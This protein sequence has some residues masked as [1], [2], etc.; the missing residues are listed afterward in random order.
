M[1]FM[2][3]EVQSLVH[4]Q[5]WHV[6]P[7]VVN[8]TASQ[9]DEALVHDHSVQCED[10][11]DELAAQRSLFKTMADGD[12]RPVHDAGP[13]LAKMWHRIDHN[14]LRPELNEPVPPP[15][16]SGM[17][18]LRWTRFL[19]A[20][21]VVQAVGL[22]ALI[23]MVW[24]PRPAPEYVTLSQPPAQP[25]PATIRLVPAPTLRLSE[26]QTLL[27]EAGLRIVQTNEDGSI[28]GVV[29]VPQ[30]TRVV[31]DALTRLKGHPGV[32][33]AE[34]VAAAGSH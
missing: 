32:L 3:E 29:L 5:A 34:P 7:W 18:H 30:D 20:A 22:A 14:D 12:A 24:Q 33:L 27:K 8:G 28:L 26:L 4:R 31:A 16:S 17:K 13:A 9:A 10:C 2:D 1:K 11:R 19:A 15:A 6:I 25:E 21:V 23:G